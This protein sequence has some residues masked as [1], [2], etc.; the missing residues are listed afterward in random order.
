MSRRTIILSVALLLAVGALVFLTISKS[1]NYTI[2]VKDLAGQYQGGYVDFDKEGI[3]KC[4]DFSRAGEYIKVEFKAIKPGKVLAQIYF[5]DEKNKIIRVDIDE[6]LRV[7]R[8][9]MVIYR[10]NMFSGWLYVLAMESLIFMLL[11][12]YFWIEYILNKIYRYYSFATIMDMGLAIMFS[13]LG[14]MFIA[15]TSYTGVRYCDYTS[16]IAFTLMGNT[17]NLLIIATIPFVVIF[18]LFMVVTNLLLIKHEGFRVQNLLGAVISGLLV[19]GI[20]ASLYLKFI[21]FGRVTDTRT[22]VNVIQFVITSLFALFECLLTASAIRCYAAAK[23]KP[24]YDGDYVV[25]L[26]CGMRKDGTLTPLLR[27]RVDAAIEYYENRLEICGKKT[28]IIASGGKGPDEVMSESQAMYNYLVRNGIP[29]NQIICEDQSTTTYENMLFSKNTIGEAAGEQ[30][31]YY[32]TTGYHVFRGGMIAES[33]GLNVQ[34]IGSK[35]KIYFWPNAFVR[36]FVGMLVRMRKKLIPLAAMII[37][38][39]I[40]SGLMV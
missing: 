20:C 36:E 21:T 12:G 38:I 2:Y 4:T 1:S 6:S 39:S 29:K 7:N 17:M 23:R 13:V 15:L 8:L 11:A 30:R 16:V 28:F 5:T 34:G 37:V 33:V 32:A 10:N 18:G 25:I 35:T 40:V 24:M 27:G 22:V 19:F 3:V 9:G 14:V 31:V 26:G